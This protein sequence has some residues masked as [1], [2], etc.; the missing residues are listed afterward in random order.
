MCSK[1]K[2]LFS[3]IFIHYNQI[4]QQCSEVAKLIAKVARPAAVEVA[5]R[6]VVVG[7]GSIDPAFWVSALG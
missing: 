4:N 2:C 5:R 3:F 1:K 7:G 6:V